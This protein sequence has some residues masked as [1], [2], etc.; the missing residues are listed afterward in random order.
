MKGYGYNAAPYVTFAKKP[1][2]AESVW[3]KYNKGQQPKYTPA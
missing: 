3:K 1:V 2:P